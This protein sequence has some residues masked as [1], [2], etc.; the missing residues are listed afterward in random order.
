LTDSSGNVREYTPDGVGTQPGKPSVSGPTF[1]GMGF[2]LGAGVHRPDDI[3]VLDERPDAVVTTKVSS[4]LVAPGT[5]VSVSGAVTHLGHAVPYPS[6]AVYA[7]T[8]SG[9]VL[10]GVT[11]G[12]ATGTF[13]RRVVPT[14]PTVYRVLFLGSDRGGTAAPATL[15]GRIGVRVA[16]PQR[17]LVPVRTVTVR[18]GHRGTLLVTV[19]PLRI[20]VLVYLQRQSGS[21][22]RNVTSARTSSRGAV[23]LTVAR[24]SAPTV[25][26]WVAVYD[27]RYLAAT[28]ST[29]TVRRG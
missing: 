16:L 14:K 12:T 6:V 13:A 3:R 23:S 29:V 4:S 10:V 27:G 8:A 9:T 22:W 17:L 20:G 25:Y 5:A 28:S 7:Q 11:R 26:R 1:T 21:V 24:P 19:S 15:G 2:D 18:A